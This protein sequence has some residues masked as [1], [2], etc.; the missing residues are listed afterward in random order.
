MSDLIQQFCEV[1]RERDR[2]RERVTVLEAQRETLERSHFDGT[3]AIRSLM[4]LFAAS[5]HEVYEAVRQRLADDGTKIISLE[6]KLATYRSALEFYAAAGSWQNDTV[7][8]N[9]APV[10]VPFTA[11][12]FMDLGDRAREALK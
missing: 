10:S 9:G 11:E 6:S 7:E 3:N 1:E 4:G 12:I 2:L 5:P 8:A